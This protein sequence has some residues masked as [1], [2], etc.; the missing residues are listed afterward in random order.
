MRDPHVVA[1]YYRLET[2]PSLIFKNPQPLDQDVDEFT[3]RLADGVLTCTMKEHYAS[4]EEAKAVVAP[5]LRAWELDFA[6]VQ[7]QR[8]LRF[9]Y[10]KDEIIDR[11]PPPPGMPQVIQ[12][13]AAIAAEA[14]MQVSAY[15]SRR[16]Y[17]APPTRFTAS[18]D[19][20][21]LWHRYEG[22]KQGHEPLLAD[23]SANLL[24]GFE[25]SILQSDRLSAGVSGS[26]HPPGRGP[27]EGS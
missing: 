16:E 5:F 19:V 10:Q 26:P 9:I 15:I 18:P 21:T 6:L 23:V 7:G 1:L 4:A 13:S 27:M 2:D 11:D 8:E 24:Y 17:P 14:A 25:P 3:L 12:V 22:Y 20:E